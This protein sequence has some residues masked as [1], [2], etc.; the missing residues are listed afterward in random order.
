MTSGEV[1][2]ALDILLITFWRFKN[3]SVGRID[4]EGSEKA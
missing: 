1:D 3:L 4:L 2:L